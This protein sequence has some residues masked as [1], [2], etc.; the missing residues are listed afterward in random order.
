MESTCRSR[1]RREVVSTHPD[2]RAAAPRGEEQLKAMSVAL[3]GVRQ[4]VDQLAAALAA[5]RQQT[6]GDI[7]TLQASQQ[8]ILRK[9]SAPAR[10]TVPP[11]LADA[12]LR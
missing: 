5:G 11:P 12:P 9:I 2:K 10:S 3:A 7:A 4:S 6:A 8:A 1:R